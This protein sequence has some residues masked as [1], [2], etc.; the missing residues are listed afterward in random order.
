MPK[1]TFTDQENKAPSELIAAGD[2]EVEVIK[3]ESG[4][5]NSGK[6]NGCEAFDFQV[7]VAKHPGCTIWE[8]ITFGYEPLQWK[9]DV[10][11]KCL[12]FLFD[13][14]PLEKGQA[15]DIA[16]EDMIGL[17]GWVTVKVEDY[18]A[19]TGEMRK[20]NR[21]AVWRTDKPKLPRNTPAA[22]SNPFA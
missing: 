9:L 10:V 19:S 11:L 21:V 2:Y 8:D 18:R 4:L 12:N 20:T 17:R 7:R 15:F 14:R 3:C 13:G 16:P 22:T 6:T 5:R 1:V